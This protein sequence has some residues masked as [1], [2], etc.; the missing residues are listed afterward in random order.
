MAVDYWASYFAGL[1]VADWFGIVVGGVS[2]V[3]SVIIFVF[4]RRAERE[5]R[6]VRDSHILRGLLRLMLISEQMRIIL[7]GIRYQFD[8]LPS[9]EK[10]SEQVLRGFAYEHGFTLKKEMQGELDLI[11]LDLPIDLVAKIDLTISVLDMFEPSRTQK[12]SQQPPDYWRSRIPF[13]EMQTSSL[14]NELKSKIAS[15]E[16]EMK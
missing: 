9:L 4:Q 7:E 14:F 6:R 15:L 8:E 5:I 2:L 16:S 3:F 13:L 1:N 11:R 12:S 10:G